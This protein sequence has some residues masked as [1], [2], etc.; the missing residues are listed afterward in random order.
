M[1]L[2]KS[3]TVFGLL[4]V[5]SAV[6]SGCLFCCLSTVW[7][8]KLFVIV[9]DVTLNKHIGLISRTK[10]FGDAYELIRLRLAGLRDRL[11]AADGLQPD[12]LTKKSQFD[13]FTVST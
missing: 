8:R 5:I 11:E 12:I 2:I 7:I 4:S 3:K 10:D 9:C 6:D 1:I 13:Q